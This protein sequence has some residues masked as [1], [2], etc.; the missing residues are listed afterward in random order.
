M[1]FAARRRARRLVAYLG[2]ERR[3]LRQGFA[4]L[5]LGAFTATLAGV[6]LASISDTLEKLPGLLILIPAT[7]GMRGTIFGAMAARL[8]T[9]TH[10]GLFE[11]TRERTGILYQNVVAAVTL[12]LFSAPYLAVLAKAS[13]ISFGL[14]S[15]PF[16]DFVTIAVVGGVLDS[17]LILLLTIGLSV[18]SYRRGYDMDAVSTPLITATAD[19]VTIPA[20]YAATFLTRISWLSTAIGVVGLMGCLLVAARGALTDLPLARR[21]F[22]EMLAVVLLTPLLDILAGTV[23]EPRIDRFVEFPVLLVLVPPFVAT[24]GSLGGILSSRLSS[25]LQL[26]IVTPRG[27]PE[28]PAVVDAGLVAGFAVVTFAFLGVLG[29]LYSFIGTA[30][31]PGV[32]ALLGGTLLAGTLATVVVAV[33]VAYYVA[34]VTTRFGLDP[35]NHSVPII[36]SVMDL[37]GILAFLSVLSLLGVAAH[38]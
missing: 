7:L 6:V 1:A 36:T 14:D 34:I 3:T 29:I 18:L 10:A 16:L 19:M 21:V 11:V 17:S 15:I 8:G 32:V 12:T 27:R 30:L 20:L 9:S 31:S 25:K 5:L 37:A 23:L 4:A 38:G 2:S 33:P 28:G 24:A 26:G 35:D 13:A 22:F